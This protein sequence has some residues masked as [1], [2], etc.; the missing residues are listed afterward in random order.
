[1]VLV[2]RYQQELHL[3]ALLQVARANK[4]VKIA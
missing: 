2:P 3:I 1:M 4:L